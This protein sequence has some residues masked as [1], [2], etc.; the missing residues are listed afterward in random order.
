MASAVNARRKGTRELELI[1]QSLRE[2]G[3][4][5]ERERERAQAVAAHVF[6][7]CLVSKPLQSRSITL[8]PRRSDMP[9]LAQSPF[10]INSI[11]RRLN[12]NQRGY[13]PK[14]KE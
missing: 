11:V 14:E 3:R 7:D 2:R 10:S 12:L 5:R 1:K 9:I 8:L 13:R 4:E 6:I